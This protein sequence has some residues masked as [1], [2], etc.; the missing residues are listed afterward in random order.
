MKC[1]RN[2]DIGDNPYI[3]LTILAR[4]YCHELNYKPKKIATTLHTFIKSTYP[5]YTANI[6]EW[7][8]TIEKISKAA[9]KYMLFESDG[10]WITEGEFEKIAELNNTI[11]EKLM[12]TMLCI[13]KLNNQKS[14]NNNYWVNTDIKEIFEMAGIKG[15]IKSR[16]KRIGKLIKQGYI[17]FANRIDNLN[18]QVLFHDE[19]GEKKLVVTDFREL[20]NEYLFYCGG[21][22]IRCAECGRLVKNNKNRTKKYCSNCAVYTPGKTKIVT[23]VDCGKA[24]V[25]KPLNTKT[26]RCRE[27]QQI[28]RKEMDRQRKK[29]FINKS[30]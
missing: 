16:A 8:D 13:A 10:V 21:D 18:I 9:S 1:I 27:C 15:T 28:R 3:T 14:E 6:K 26:C 30:K 17:R 12:F 11:M 25:V 20:G 19:D 22:F 23:C 5:R 24:F 7:T 2:N 29:S 4:Y